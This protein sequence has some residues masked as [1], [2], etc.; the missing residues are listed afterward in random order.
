MKIKKLGFVF[1][2]LSS[3]LLTGCAT[4]EVITADMFKT[5]LEKYEFVVEDATESYQMQTT[6]NKV[7]VATK[8]TD[9]YQVEFYEF[10]NEETAIQIFENQKMIIEEAATAKSHSSVEAVN[11]DKYEQTSD[12]NYGVVVRVENT[13]IYSLVNLEHKEEIKEI[14]KE[15]NY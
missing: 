1:L 10:E 15:L 8:N 4:K 13:L 7:L 5:T 9:I 14:L 2:L 3:L 11:Y 6:F 12:I